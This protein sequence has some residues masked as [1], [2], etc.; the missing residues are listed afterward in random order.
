MVNPRTVLYV[1]TGAEFW[2]GQRSLY[3][4]ISHLDRSLYKPVIAIPERSPTTALFG[5]SVD[6]HTFPARSAGEQR[7][8][9]P[10]KV[11]RSIFVLSRLISNIKPE[12]I[13]ANTFLGG[14]ILSLIPSLK[15]PWILHQRDLTDHGKLTDWTTRR[16]TKIIAAT[17]AAAAHLGR[18][19]L[20]Y[21]PSIIP[22]GVSLSFT[23]EITKP[24][25]KPTLREKHGIKNDDILVGTVGTISEQ[26]SQHEILEAADRLRDIPR[27]RFICV[28]NPYREED[29]RYFDRLMEK[30]AA[31]NLEHIV[32][33][34]GFTD[35][36]ANVYGSIDILAHPGKREGMGRV[37]IEAMGAGIPVLA[38]DCYGPA[39]LITRD[40]D[41]VLCDEHD[42][43]DF[44]DKLIKLV[45]EE[46]YR[47]RL[48]RAGRE[49]AFEEFTVEGSTRRI[50]GVYEQI[51]TRNETP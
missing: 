41:G 43:E 25:F 15:T 17:H 27:L 3:E 49:K 44:V 20:K 21:P 2:G 14:F 23:E 31:S 39:E 32:S 8:T 22:H 4:L 19:G 38:K 35:D 9:K 36:L 10:F 28:G 12:I 11:L 33:F 16:A 37:V 40:V 26:K 13:H 18:S 6:V 47:T 50:E 46:D 1:D 51:L 29:K 45:T 5:E 34:E 42:F 7:A 48:A 24:E 30:R